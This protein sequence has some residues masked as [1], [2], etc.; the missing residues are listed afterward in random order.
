MVGRTAS[1]VRGAVPDAP[2]AGRMLA[3]LWGRQRSRQPP[4]RTH[5]ATSTSSRVNDG[6]TNS[7]AW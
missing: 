5:R 7:S 6:A 3:T 1:I 2:I 4:V